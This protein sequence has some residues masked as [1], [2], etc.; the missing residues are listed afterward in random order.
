MKRFLAGSP[1]KKREI[2]A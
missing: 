1:K 2:F